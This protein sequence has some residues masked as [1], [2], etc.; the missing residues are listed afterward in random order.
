M[1]AG[2]GVHPGGSAGSR[3]IRLPGLSE[4]GAPWAGGVL[5]VGSLC[6]RYA[7]TLPRGGG[8]RTW[9]P[10]AYSGAESPVTA[11][12]VAAASLTMTNT[13]SSVVIDTP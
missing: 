2:G 5:P 6:I 7:S 11:V 1:P 4:T 10:V 12:A 13:S 8:V 3:R 9:K